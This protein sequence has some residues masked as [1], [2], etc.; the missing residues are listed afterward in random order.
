M[1]RK[2]C[3]AMFFLMLFAVML[4][5]APDSPEQNWTNFVRIAAY[6]LQSHNADQIVT[7]CAG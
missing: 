6:G 2:S 4:A 3:L 5:A 1:K 7:K